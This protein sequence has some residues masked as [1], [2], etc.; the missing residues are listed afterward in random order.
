MVHEIVQAD[1]YFNFAIPSPIRDYI[2][3]TDNMDICIKGNFN[4]ALSV[5]LNNLKK[6]KPT[7]SMFYFSTKQLRA[8]E[9]I[10]DN[11]ICLPDKYDFDIDTQEEFDRVEKYLRCF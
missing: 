1:K 2:N 6:P 10:D 8:E 5:N 3:I 9:I 7:G 11:S 4:S